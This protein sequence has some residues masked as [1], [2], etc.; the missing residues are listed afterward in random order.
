MQRLVVR[1]VQSHQNVRIRSH[2]CEKFRQFAARKRLRPVVGDLAARQYCRGTLPN[3]GVDDGNADNQP[4]GDADHGIP[5]SHDSSN[6]R[7]EGIPR[8]LQRVHTAE[9]DEHACVAF[10]KIQPAQSPIVDKNDICRGFA[11]KVLPQGGKVG[12]IFLEFP[13][14]IDIGVICFE[15]LFPR[16][17][18]GFVCRARPPRDAHDVRIRSPAASR[19]GAQPRKT[20]DCGKCRRDFLSHHNRYSLDHLFLWCMPDAPLKAHGQR[21]FRMDGFDDADDRCRLFRRHIHFAPL[22]DRMIQI[23]IQKAGAHVESGAVV[24]ALFLMHD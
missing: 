2:V 4:Y 23:L 20:H 10:V 21:I 16:F 15:L 1:N 3:G 24:L 9:I 12:G 6:G 5:K 8:F 13:L 18:A 17:E 11:D 22:R 7:H 19:K 14:D